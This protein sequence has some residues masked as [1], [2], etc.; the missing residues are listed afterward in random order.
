MPAFCAGVPIHQLTPSDLESRMVYECLEQ[1]AFDGPSRQRY[2]GFR[3]GLVMGW[4]CTGF[5]PAAAL[6]AELPLRH[7]AKADDD[8]CHL[9]WQ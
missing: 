2:S 1:G 8:P 6:G 9:C 3:A 7:K 5:G 4:F